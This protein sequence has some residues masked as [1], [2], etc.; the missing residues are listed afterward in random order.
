ME[1]NIN[2][3]LQGE[4]SG[5]SR[6]AEADGRAIGLGKAELNFVLGERVPRLLV[7]EQVGGGEVNWIFQLP[8]RC[9]VGMN[10]AFRV[11]FQIHL[12]LAFADDVAGLGIVFKIRAVDLIEAAGIAPVQR[13]GDVMQFGVSALLVL[14]RLAGFNLEYGVSL[15]GAGN[16]EPL[17]ALLDLNSDFRRHLLERV[18]HP[19][20]GVE[21][22]RRHHQQEADGAAREPAPKV[23][24][25]DGHLQASLL[26]GK[27]RGDSR[28]RC[29]G[30]AQLD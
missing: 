17:G 8:G 25:L 11:G 20:P 27:P 13:D 15:F 29:P 22:H 28:P 30:R 10:D 4:H 1:R 24:N 3:R 21:I 19:V 16:S 12:D 6:V 23:G 18:L 9:L 7:K 2:L 14:H 26:E 5:V